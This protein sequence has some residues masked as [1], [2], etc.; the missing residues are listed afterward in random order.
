MRAAGLGGAA[1]GAAARTLTHPPPLPEIRLALTSARDGS[2]ML[3]SWATAANAT[4]ADYA[5]VVKYGASAAALSQTSAPA[6]TRNYTLC[7]LPSPFLHTATMTG[8]KAGATYFYSVV[9]PGC[10]ATAPVQFTAP[11][12][13]GD[14]ASAYP[15]TVFA[16]GDMGITH[17][18]TTADFIT[19]RV[20]TAAGRP[21]VITHAGDISYA[22]NREAARRGGR[23]TAALTNTP[24]PPPPSLPRRLPALR[25]GAEHV[26]QRDLALRLAGARHVLLGQP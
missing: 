6:A 2:A 11:R 12:V 5:G 1:A 8:L 16:Y 19:A 21:D 9:A 17:S 24:P 20:G 23:V 13:V 14:K 18:Q 3:V 26:L 25:H 10:G 4:P 15:F 22:D 7:E